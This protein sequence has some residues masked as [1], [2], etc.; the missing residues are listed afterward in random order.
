ML[1]QKVYKKKHDNLRRVIRLE[2]YRQLRVEPID[3]W[4]EHDPSEAL[5]SK[6]YRM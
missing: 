1:A 3:K 5:E 2:H 6:K 4:Y